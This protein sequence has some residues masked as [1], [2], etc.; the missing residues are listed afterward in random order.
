MANFAFRAIVPACL[1]LLLLAAPAGALPEKPGR[2]VDLPLRDGGKQRVLVSAPPHARAAIVMLPGGA[3]DIGIRRD[4]TLRH[5][6]NFVVRTRA[7]WTA[8]GYAIVVPDAIDGVS[9]RGRRSSPA[10]ARIVGQLVAF[11]QRQTAGPVFLLG[12]SQGS[13][14]AM[15][16]A[17]QA[18]AGSVAGVVLTESVSVM[19]GSGETVFGADPARVRVP[20]LIVANRDDRCTVA[21]PDAAQRIAA[22]MTASRAVRIL[23]VSGG[24]TRSRD[25]CG[26]LTPHGYFGIEDTVVAA[27]DRWMKGQR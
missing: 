4:G 8:R 18:A 6:D 5:G 7:L 23:T 3:G 25:D 20:A 2:V 27:I 13:I 1:G 15:N 26:S 12:T 24:V 17:A 22:A 19:G 16:G 21:P 14:A 9:L 11:A 10:Y